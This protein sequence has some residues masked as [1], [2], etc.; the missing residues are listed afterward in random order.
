[1]NILMAIHIAG[2]LVALP[3]TVRGSPGLFVLAFAPFGVMAF[4]LVRVRLG[5]RW[6]TTL[7]TLPERSMT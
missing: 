2:G 3:A 4:W 1:M 5:R 6:R 7:P